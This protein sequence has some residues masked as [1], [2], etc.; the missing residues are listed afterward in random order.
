MDYTLHNIPLSVLGRVDSLMFA[1]FS[2]AAIVLKLKLTSRAGNQSGATNYNATKSMENLAYSMYSSREPLFFEG[3]VLVVGCVLLVCLMVTYPLPN[4]RYLLHWPRALTGMV[5]ISTWSC[6]TVWFDS[7]GY[8]D[9]VKR[10]PELA[11]IN[12]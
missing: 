3:V 5:A 8:G 2:L 9:V 4:C 11:M 10:P 7:S 6:T 12:S 1:T